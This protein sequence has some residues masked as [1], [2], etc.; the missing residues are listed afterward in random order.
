MRAPPS[1]RH[2]GIRPARSALW[3]AAL[4]ACTRLG[5]AQERTSPELTQALVRAMFPGGATGAAP[6]LLVGRVPPEIA[7][8]LPLP[9]GARV[10]GSVRH[11]WGVTV[12]ATATAGPDSVREALARDMAARG[13][14]SAA[15]RGPGGLRPA[16]T[17]FPLAL[18]RGDT[19]EVHVTTARRAGG[20]TDVRLD[21]RTGERLSCGGRFGHPG[22]PDPAEMPEMPTLYAPPEPGGATPAACARGER[23]G[24][25][26]QMS[27][28]M[29]VPTDLSAKALLGY[30]TRQLEGAGWAGAPGGAG[31]AV[32]TWVR[33]EASGIMSRATLSIT[34]APDGAPCHHVSLTVTQAAEAR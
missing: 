32:G 18:C 29:D 30:Y 7:P 19:A 15:E 22:P 23:G 5:W 11:A 1:S 17:L 24:W 34:D 21:F 14:A 25:G 27:M 26:G 20:P 8:E 9:R 6:E 33:R 12:L 31:T 13:W 28:S 4:C 10:L 3:L 16:P 2:R